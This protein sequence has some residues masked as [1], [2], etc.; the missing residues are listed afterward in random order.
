LTL[1]VRVRRQTI[2]QK[3]KKKNLQIGSRFCRW[4]EVEKTS[5]AR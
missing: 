4:R 5:A 1:G 2:E 3:T